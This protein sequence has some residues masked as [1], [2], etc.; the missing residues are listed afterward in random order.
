LYFISEK[1]VDLIA[2]DIVKGEAPV[3]EVNPG[4]GF[5]SRGLLVAGIRQLWLCEPSVSF[6]HQMKVN[7]Y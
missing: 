2:Q 5:I 4:L 3:F 7:I 1:I 6:A